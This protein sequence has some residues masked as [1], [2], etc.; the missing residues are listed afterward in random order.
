MAIFSFFSHHTLKGCQSRMDAWSLE[1]KVW[2]KLMDCTSYPCT[3][4]R[5]KIGSFAFWDKIMKRSVKIA[6]IRLHIV[7]LA[8][9]PAVK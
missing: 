9:D 4:P 3:L 7:V 6:F 5:H 1:T 2:K 8:F